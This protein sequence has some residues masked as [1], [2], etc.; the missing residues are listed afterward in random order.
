MQIRFIS[1]DGKR[2]TRDLPYDNG[3]P[4]KIV[5]SRMELQEETNAET[6]KLARALFDKRLSTEATRRGEG[7]VQRALDIM[8]T[9]TKVD[10]R[11]ACMTEALALQTLMGDGT[12]TFRLYKAKN[13][14][15]AY[16]ELGTVFNDLTG[17]DLPAPIKPAGLETRHGMYAREAWSDHGPP[18]TEDTLKN[19]EQLDGN[20]LLKTIQRN[21]DR[22]LKEQQDN[23][24]RKLE[25]ARRKAHDK[26]AAVVAALD[27]H[28]H[29]RHDMP[30][31]GPTGPF[32]KKFNEIF[33]AAA[34]VL[35]LDQNA[36]VPVQDEGGVTLRE[37]PFTV[38][39]NTCKVNPDYAHF[40]PCKC[41]K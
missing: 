3:L 33:N 4:H 21:L 39:D 40:E 19:A 8:W 12:R 7:N 6:E 31:L 18:I 27:K 2:F 9:K 41:V 37:K 17:N 24:T 5:L 35:P 26:C 16:L 14:S 20:K 23:K 1:K 11:E 25:E 13:G 29:I 32:S 15:E 28:A 22:E 36:V 10:V 34:A 38:W 30:L